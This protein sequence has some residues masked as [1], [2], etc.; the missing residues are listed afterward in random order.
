M[1]TLPSSS[2]QQALEVMGARLRSIRREASLSGRDLARLAGWHSS[3][4]SRIEHA[5]RTPSPA[6]VR[7]WCRHCGVPEQAPD[8]VASLE[9][10]E[11]MFVEWRHMERTGLKKAQEAVVPRWER[12]R[13][14]RIYSSKLI[15]GPL[16]T[17]AYISAILTALMRRR[18]LP[19]DVEE[20]VQVRV[21]KQHVL[22]DGDHRFA[23]ILEESVLRAPI[24]GAE[25]MAGQL[26]HL[27]TVSALPSMSLGIIPLDADRSTMW[28][29]EGFFM[30][31][32]AEVTVEL[33]SGHLTIT[34]PHEVA[35][36]AGAFKEL[37]AL[38]VYGKAARALITAAIQALDRDA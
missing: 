29:A 1:T 19:N 13:H 22:H 28:P 20:A 6:D 15:P 25:V 16:Q 37:A 33:V 11:G 9:A 21:D 30:F 14:F 3:K 12:T 17:R 23:V 24:G 26:G 32:D 7:A 5:Q 31:D 36:Y 10:I 18:G 38:A 4:V 8:L 35:L 2:A 34:Q 27:L